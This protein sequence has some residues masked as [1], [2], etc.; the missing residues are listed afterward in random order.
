MLFRSILENNIYG[1]DLNEESVEI[2]KLSLWLRT[3]QPRRKLN[4]LNNNIK[5]GNSLID[6]PKVAGDKAFNW[7]N[8][9]PKVFANGGF[10]VVIGNPPY[11]RAELLSEFQEYLSNNYSLYNPSGDLF[12]YFYEKSFNLL[13][14]ETGLFGFISNT[15]DKTTAGISIRGYLQTEISF[16][17][18]IDFTEVQ[19]FEGATT[20][21]VIIT[22]QN[23]TNNNITRYG[24]VLLISS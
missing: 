7:Q 9:F 4:S 15:F 20:Y 12:S 23:I 17:K 1:V 6:D 21:P 18:Y 2:A 5:C 3:A 11:V 24:A 14:P 19:I 13:K 10:D 8:E 16:F 22:A